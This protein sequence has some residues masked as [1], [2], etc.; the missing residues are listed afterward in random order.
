MKI[1]EKIVRWVG[2]CVLAHR[3]C[4]RHVVDTEWNVDP[5]PLTTAEIREKARQHEEQEF[6]A[7]FGGDRLDVQHASK[8]G[9]F[10]RLIR[11]FGRRRVAWR[12]H[13]QAV[14]EARMDDA[15]LPPDSEMNSKAQRIEAACY[16]SEVVMPPIIQRDDA[17]I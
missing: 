14:Q 3:I 7:A 1:F 4:H 5:P 2:R 17:R 16:L 8:A 11:S 10:E 13:I 12:L 9:L 6:H 15:D